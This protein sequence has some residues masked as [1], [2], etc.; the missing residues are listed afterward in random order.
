MS[1]IL[2]GRCV[3]ATLLITLVFL[4]GVAADSV[5]TDTKTIWGKVVAMNDDG[6]SF[7]QGCNTEPSTLSWEESAYV[8][9]N[10]DCKQPTH[11]TGPG[12]S[13]GWGPPGCEKEK[14]FIFD[15]QGEKLFA[16]HVLL[17]NAVFRI[18]LVN[19]GGRLTGVPSQIRKVQS[20]RRREVCVDSLPKTFQSPEG[21]RLSY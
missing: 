13:I 7:Q 16:R 1:L 14:V 17:D 9:F 4:S 15:Y 2:P 11:S 6:I 10:E 19:N 18:D 8:Q 5:D 3:F 20:V 12:G 21:M